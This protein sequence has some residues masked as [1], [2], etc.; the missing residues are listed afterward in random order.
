MVIAENDF[1]IIKN[2]RKSLLYHKD[3][4]WKRKESESCFAH[5]TMGINNGAEIWERTEIYILTKLSNLAPREDSGLYRDDGPILLL[6]NTNGQFEKELERI[7]KNVRKLF[8]E[9]GFKIE[10]E[11]NLKTVNL[12]NIEHEKK[13]NLV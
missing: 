4:A 6:R 5:V 10:I 11:T 7:R 9:I 2:C 3:E 8:K 12:K 1:R 13:G